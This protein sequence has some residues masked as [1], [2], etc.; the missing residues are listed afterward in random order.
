MRE[1]APDGA[2]ANGIGQGGST[3]R[4]E[5]AGR[6]DF[7]A[8]HFPGRASIEEVRRRLTPQA[9]KSCRMDRHSPTRIHSDEKEVRM[10]TLSSAIVLGLGFLM[11]AGSP[12][13]AQFGDMGDA[14]KKG[15]GDAA[16][17]EIM[18][19]AA[20]KAGLPTPGAPAAAPGTGAASAPEVA[21]GA[22]EAPAAAPGADAGAASA[23]ADGPKVAPGAMDE[24]AGAP[25]AGGTEQ[26]GGE[27]D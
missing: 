25:G 5:R 8:D 4:P 22:V 10:K 14:V 12:A 17:Q 9:L 26:D 7:T 16:K 19:G 1:R 27:E 3:R 23:P 6:K 18:K 20:E 11:L 24:P 2:R 13:R 21:P 15:A